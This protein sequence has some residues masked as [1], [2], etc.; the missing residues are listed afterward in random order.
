VHIGISGGSEEPVSVDAGV[1]VH[2]CTSLYTWCMTSAVTI[3]EARASLPALVERVIAGEEVT[4]T[5]HGLPVAVLVRPDTLRARR[6]DAA[7]AVAADVD[8]ALARGRRTPLSERAALSRQR[9][10]ALVADV[11]RARAAR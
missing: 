4:V 10:D 9:A 3:S 6:A 1:D 5:R 7:L 8:E 2:R 11:R